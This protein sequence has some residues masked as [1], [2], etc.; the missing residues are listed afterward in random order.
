MNFDK[1]FDAIGALVVLLIPFA[2][3]GFVALIF[4]VAPAIWDFV[5]RLR[6]DP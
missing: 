5:S 6:L 1:A 4:W 3:L 2:I